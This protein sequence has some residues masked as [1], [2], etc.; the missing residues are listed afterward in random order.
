MNTLEQGDL[1]EVSAIEWLASVGAC[2]FVPVGHSADVD[3]VAELDGTLIGVQV[4]TSRYFHKRRWVVAVCTRGGNQSWSG[5]VK[6][7][8]A[9]R[10]DYLFALVEDGR[11]WFIPSDRVG[12]G[13]AILLGGPKYVDFEVDRGRPLRDYDR[14]QEPL[15]NR[16]L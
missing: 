8:D 10:C 7:M 9:S 5:L 2:V 3:I 4:K 6:R 16:V 14:R 12:G 13:N 15:Y 11:R 1:G